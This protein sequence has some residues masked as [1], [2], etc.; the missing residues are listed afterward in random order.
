[1]LTGVGCHFLLQGILPGIKSP[2]PVSLAL[3]GGFFT[4]SATWEAYYL[5]IIVKVLNIVH[6]R[7]VMLTRTVR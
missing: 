4:P 7:N 2:S 1:M 5:P 6:K 3:A